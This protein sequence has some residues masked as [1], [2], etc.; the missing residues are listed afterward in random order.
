MMHNTVISPALKDAK[1]D[2]D[3]PDF[4][5]GKGLVYKIRTGIIIEEKAFEEGI[6]HFDGFKV[7]LNDDDKTLR[8]TLGQNVGRCVAAM[9]SILMIPI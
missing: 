1:I 6:S 4:E 5:T 9:E 7:D 8:L 3:K 2:A